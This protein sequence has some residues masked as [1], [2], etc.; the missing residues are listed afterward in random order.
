MQ[1]FFKHLFQ[2]PDYYAVI[3]AYIIAN[4]SKA[5]IYKVDISVLCARF[6]VTNSQVRDVLAHGSKYSGKINFS[7]TVNPNGFIQVNLSK[8]TPKQKSESD[9]ELDDKVTEVMDYFN[10][11]LAKYG[12]RG[13]KRD[14]KTSVAYIKKR[15]IEGYSIDELKDVIDVKSEWLTHEV[16]HKYFRPQT[17]FNEKFESYLN[18]SNQPIK[19]T[20]SEKRNEQ[21]TDAVI[22]AANDTY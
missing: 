7:F 4:L 14:G 8:I 12:K 20:K 1:N 6:N 3:W 15:L 5:M 19:Q 21:F 16:Y 11:V 17:I 2:R 18:E 22:R 13:Y 10:K 9:K